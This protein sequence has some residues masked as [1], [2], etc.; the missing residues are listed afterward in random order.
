MK[1]AKRSTLD[2]GD[3][4]DPGMATCECAFN[5]TELEQQGGGF[6][7]VAFNGEDIAVGW[8]WDPESC[9]KDCMAQYMGQLSSNGTTSMT[10]LCEGLK[11]EGSRSA[12]WPLYWCDATYCGV[13]NNQS[14]S[15]RE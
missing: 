8:N 7:T 4:G 1:H 2:G 11:N 13:W 6:R 3:G 12:L 15:D 5:G 14:G 9:L 10:S